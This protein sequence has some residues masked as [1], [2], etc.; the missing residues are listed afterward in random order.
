[1]SIPPKRSRA[2]RLMQLYRLRAQVEEEIAFLE[3]DLAREKDAIERA[4]EAARANRLCG[5]DGGYYHHRRIQKNDA[6]TACKQ[7][8]A[9]AE[10]DRKRRRQEGAA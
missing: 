10:A 2:E 1:M 3:R 7:A 5:T 4:R 8:H 6:C 9:A